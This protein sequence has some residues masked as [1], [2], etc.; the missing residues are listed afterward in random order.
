MAAGSLGPCCGTGV[1]EFVIRISGMVSNRSKEKKK[2][3]AGKAKDN[4]SEQ[5]LVDESEWDQEEEEQD[6]EKDIQDL[7]IKTSLQSSS[8]INVV[9]KSL[10]KHY[11]CIRKLNKIY[12]T[13]QLAVAH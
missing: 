12:S 5:S 8:N 10:A 1:D 9:Y 2:K 4:E 11:G 7:S 13:L 3:M 6:N